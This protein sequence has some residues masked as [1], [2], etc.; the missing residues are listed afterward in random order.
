MLTR[1]Q[2]RREMQESERLEEQMY[3]NLSLGLLQ[4]LQIPLRALYDTMFTAT[5]SL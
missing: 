4:Q 2:L 5:Q 3:M 1:E